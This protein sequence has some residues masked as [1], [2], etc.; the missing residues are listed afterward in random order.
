MG[1]RIIKIETYGMKGIAEPMVF[2]FQNDTVDFKK[3]VE[4]PSIKAIYGMNGS[5]KSSFINAIDVYRNLSWSFSYLLESSSVRRLNNL[6]NKRTKQFSFKVW[7]LYSPDN[8]VFC[9]EIVVDNSTSKP[10]ITKERLSRITGKTVNGPEKLLFDISGN[11][12]MSFYDDSDRKGLSDF[13]KKTMEKKNEYCSAIS[14]LF[15]VNF[16]KSV[17]AL[18]GEEKKEYDGKSR[19]SENSV[20]GALFFTGLFVQSTS[21]YLADSDVHLEYDI[22]QMRAFLEHFGENLGDN[23]V[24]Y[25]ETLVPK[26][27]YD[28]FSLQVGKMTKFIQLFKPDLQK[29]LIDR[30]EDGDYFLCRLVMNYGDYSIDFEYESTGLKNLMSMFSCLEQA[31]LGN[32]AF[33]DEMDANMNEVYLEKLCEFF[34]NHAKGQLCFTTHNTAPMR[35]LQSRKFGIDFI[36][37][38]KGNHQ[39]VRNGNYSPAKLYAEGMIPGLPFNVEDFDFLEVFFPEEA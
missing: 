36:S 6:I 31:S 37:S 9:H 3:A 18:M 2:R 16:Q 32:I 27:Q 17:T 29:I 24:V 25:G 1:F 22:A 30:R 13:I 23:M 26:S 19:F 8:L 39:W 35:I 20:I 38:K 4:S 12:L 34:A 5:G 21:I 10:F 7:F 28:A 11:N 15:D 33:I 14:L